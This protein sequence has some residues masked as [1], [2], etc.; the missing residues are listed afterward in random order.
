VPKTERL[1]TATSMQGANSKIDYVK[2]TESAEVCL[3]LSGDDTAN[4]LMAFPLSST[5]LIRR[6][7]CALDGARRQE[8]WR[9]GISPGEP[10][11][12]IPGVKRSF[13][14]GLR[15]SAF[16]RALRVRS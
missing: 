12:S 7:H 15:I 2:E 16:F 9:F 10:N 13:G 1:E 14:D 3:V 4:F 6:T 11:S 8:H 5:R